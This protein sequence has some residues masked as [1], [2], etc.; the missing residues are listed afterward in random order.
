MCSRKQLQSVQ[1][2]LYHNHR[3]WAQ[4]A[5]ERVTKQF[6][7]WNV[8][9]ILPFTVQLSALWLENRCDLRHYGGLR[10]AS[11]HKTPLFI[12]TVGE[13]VI[14]LM[15]AALP[16]VVVTL[17][18]SFLSFISFIYAKRNTYKRTAQNTQQTKEKQMCTHTH[19]YSVNIICCKAK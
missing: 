6:Y 13:E 11:H 9:S 7:V 12:I 10:A 18:S 3:S 17:N 16:I 14:M 5:E 19:I 4:S 15:S 2:S 8:F 1:R